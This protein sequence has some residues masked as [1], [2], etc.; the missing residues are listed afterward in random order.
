MN[1]IKKFEKWYLLRSSI[2]EEVIIKIVDD[3]HI[4]IQDK[5][6]KYV[7]KDNNLIL[8]KGTEKFAV[9]KPFNDR[10]LLYKERNNFT[11]FIY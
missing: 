5:T 4:I 3:E 10:T 8:Y 9:I 2:I 1:I 7:N 6:F 11:A